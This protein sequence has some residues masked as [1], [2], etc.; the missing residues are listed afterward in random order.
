MI[1]RYNNVL[2]NNYYLVIVFSNDLLLNEGL[3]YSLKNVL[4]MNNTIKDINLVYN[5]IIKNN[6]RKIIFVD[7][8]VEYYE[9]INMFNGKYEIDFIFT[10]SVS[11]LCDETN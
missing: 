5:F 10:K 7:Y 6:F 1:N 4:R 2:Y 11:S 3:I 8:I 9:L